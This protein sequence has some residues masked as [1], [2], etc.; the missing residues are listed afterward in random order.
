MLIVMLAYCINAYWYTGAEGEEIVT[1]PPS[2]RQH[3]HAVIRFG[4]SHVPFV[5]SVIAAPE[6]A[7]PGHGFHT[8]HTHDSTNGQH[9]CCDAKGENAKEKSY[10]Q[11]YK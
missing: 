3:V 8:D 2:K 5:S 9:E 10:C 11:L 7:K 1:R 6:F 4:C